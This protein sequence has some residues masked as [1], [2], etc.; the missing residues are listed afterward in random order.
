VIAGTGSNSTNQAIELSR[1]AERAGVEAVLSVV[2]YCN[3]SS[4]AGMV[5]HFRS[6]AESVGLP[7]ILYDIPSRT[8]CGLADETVV[9]LAEISQFVD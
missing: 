8:V 5:V 6:I 1:D 2:P 3:K 4:Q 7:I 9:R